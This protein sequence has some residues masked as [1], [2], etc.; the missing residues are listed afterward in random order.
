VAAL[1]NNLWRREV[2]GNTAEKYFKW[3]DL[4]AISGKDLDLILP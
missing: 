1:F 4:T 2:D 3:D